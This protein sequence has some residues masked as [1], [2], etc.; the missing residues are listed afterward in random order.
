MPKDTT[1][2]DQPVTDLQLDQ[3][4]IEWVPIDEVSPNA[5]NPNKMTWQDHQLLKTSLLEDGWT[6][7]IVTLPN[8]TIVDGEQRWTTA[9][10]EIT[11][12]DIQEIIDHMESRKASGQPESASILKRLHQSKER[13]EQAIS[14]GLPPCIASITGGLVP[15]TTIDLGDEAH[16]ILSTIRH[17]RARG[18]HQVDA[19]AGLTKDLV[20]L[21]L[22]IDD[23][24]KRLGMDD[25]EIQ[26]ML[27]MTTEAEALLADIPNFSQAWQPVHI[28]QAAQEDPELAAALN[29]SEAANQTAADYQAQLAARNAEIADITQQELKI[30]EQE[31]GGA[32]TQEERDQIAKEAEATVPDIPKPPIESMVKMVFIVTKQEEALILQVVGKESRA[33][34]LVKLCR[35]KME[36]LQSVPA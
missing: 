19:M 16:Q 11:P 18:S 5:Y 34:G 36:H 8:K 20:S 15:I 31:K 9:Q 10:V 24:E 17:N 30:A 4:K 6:Q 25:E 32:L 27:A 21:G 7:P 23:L 29:A 14:E 12:A 26:R 28:A 22:D 1:I 3:L 35:E 33:E 2:S 13:L